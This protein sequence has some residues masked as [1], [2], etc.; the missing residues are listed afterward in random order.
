MRKVIDWLYDTGRVFRREWSN[1]FGDIGALLFF[2]ALPLLY[3]LVYTL[4]YNPEIVTELPV[5]VVDNDRSASS[6]ELVR[7]A[8]AS[9]SIGIYG[10]ASDMEEARR[11]MNEGRVCG[12]LEIPSDYSRRIGRG[13]QAVV[14]FYSQMSLLIRYRAFVSALTELQMKVASDVTIERVEMAGA[15]ALGMASLP[16]SSVSNFLGDEGQGFASFVMPGIIILILQQSMVLGICVLGGTSRERRRRNG[17]I[18]ASDVAG[19]GVTASVLGKALC[20]IVFYVPLTI[21]V[22]RF[23]PW[24]FGLPHTGSTADYFLFLFPLLLSSAFFG[25]TMVAFCRERESCFSVIVFTSVLFLFLSGLTW[26]RYAMPQLWLWV[27]DI[28]PATWGVEGFIRI[29]SNG[30]SLAEAGTAYVA[31]WILSAVYFV[32]SCLVLSWLRRRAK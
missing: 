23:V 26:P 24:F 6:R 9:P 13:E 31:M 17:G 21:Y 15:S 28:I 7:M 5:A 25:Q 4:I 16:V 14:P 2:V 32:L 18:D 22:V 8:S 27:G 30:A 29:N 19:A 11:L 1:V 20:Y 12:I 10:Y 3:P